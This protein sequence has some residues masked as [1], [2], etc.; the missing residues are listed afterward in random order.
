[1]RTVGERIDSQDEA[2]LRI[3]EKAATDIRVAAP[4]IIVAFDPVEQVAQVQIATREQL[5]DQQGNLS[6]VD[7]P[8]LVDVPVV[9]PRAGG[10]ALTLPVAAGDECL[11]VFTDAQHD[12]WW[13]S[14]GVQNR[15][16]LR[17]HDLSDA[18]A[19]LGPWSQP[20]VLPSY[21]TTAAELRTDDGLTRLTVAPGSITFTVPD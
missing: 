2:L 11:L 18:V 20:R 17:R 14:G 8:L 6:W 7:L 5:R 12:F 13:A 4:G 3:V 21:N 19:I 16:D 9:F 15:N 1:V 10:F